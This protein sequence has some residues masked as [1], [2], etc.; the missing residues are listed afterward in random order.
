M[1]ALHDDMGDPGTEK[2]SGLLRHRFYWP[3]MS[4]DIFQKCHN[5]ERCI[6][7]KA[8]PQ[9]AAPAGSLSST[10]PLQLMC[11]DFLQI[12][13]DDKGV[14]NVLVITDQFTRYA[15]AYP[16]ADQ[17]AIT[18]AKVLWEKV[19]VNYGLPER[20]HSDQGQDFTSQVI[21]ELCR[22]LNTKRA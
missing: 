20:L 5:C 11:M 19:F 13:P 21:Q 15:L 7:R 17:R 3:R 14:K 2:T 22:L 8:L 9:K 1:K 12:E 6:R 18:V 4:T 10:G 16:T